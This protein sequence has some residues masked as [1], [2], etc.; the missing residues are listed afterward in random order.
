MGPENLLQS[1]VEWQSMHTITWLARYFPRSILT[2]VDSTLIS[3]IGMFGK[4][5]TMY[6][7]MHV[8]MSIRAA[9][10]LPK[11]TGHFFFLMQQAVYEISGKFF[12]QI[13]SILPVKSRI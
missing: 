6:R 12:I 1:R 13:Y 7:I 11:I 8:T 4:N 9:T 3:L 2:G 5:Q 10:T